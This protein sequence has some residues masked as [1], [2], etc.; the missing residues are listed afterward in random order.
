LEIPFRN[1]QQEYIDNT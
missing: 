1:T